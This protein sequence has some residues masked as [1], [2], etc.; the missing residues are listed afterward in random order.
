MSNAVEKQFRHSAQTMRR[1]CYTIIIPQRQNVDTCRCSVRS[2]FN[3][4]YCIS[5]KVKCIV[6]LGIKTE[7]FHKLSQFFGSTLG[8]PRDHREPG[9]E[10]FL[11]PDGEK[12][13]LYGPDEPLQRHDC[14]RLARSLVLKWMA[15]KKQKKSWNNPA[16]NFS[17]RF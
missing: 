1:V 15:L 3:A 16:L 8:L 5:M 17:A 11:L 2:L 13:A 4:V 14:S 12:V 9:F 7:K 10:T 6:Y